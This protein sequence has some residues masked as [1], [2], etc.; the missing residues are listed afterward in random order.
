MPR[1]PISTSARMMACPA[2]VQYVEVSTVARPVTVTA[3]VDWKM[4]AW[5]AGRAFS[6]ASEREEQEPACRRTSGRGRRAAA[7]APGAGSPSAWS[8]GAPP[9]RT[10]A[11]RLRRS[12][13]ACQ[14]QDD[15]GELHVRSRQRPQA[16][17]TPAVR[18]LRRSSASSSPAPNRLWV[19]GSGIGLG[20]GALPLFLL[21]RDRLGDSTRLVWLAR[22]AAE[23]EEA[24]A[25]GFDAD[26]QGRA[27]RLLDHAAG[28]RHR[29][30][31]RVRRR[32]PLRRPRRLR[33]AALARP[34][35]QAPAPRLA[36]DVLGVVPARPRRRTP[37]AR[38]RLPPRRPRAVAVPGGVGAGPAEHRQRVRR[39]SGE[40][41]RHRRP[42]RRRAARRQRVDPPRTRPGRVLDEAVPDLPPSAR[43]V[44]FAPTW[45]DGG[46]DPTVPTA[47]E[48]DAIVAWLE[49]H[50][51]VLLVRTH[52]L[53]R[54][55]LRRRPGPVGA[56]PAA[57]AGPA[58]RRQPGP[59]GGRRRGHRLLLDRLRL[60]AG[61]TPGGVL[62]A[63][64]RRLRLDARLLPAVRGVHRR[65][66]RHHLGRCA[67]PARRGARRGSGRTGPPPRAAPA[68]G[69]LRRPR[70]PRRPIGCS[71]RSWPAPDCPVVSAR[72]DAGVGRPT[73]TGALVRPGH[74]HAHDRRTRGRGGAGRPPGPRRGGRRV[75][76][77][78]RLA[79]GLRPAGPAERHL[80]ARARRRLVAG[81]RRRRAAGDPPR[82][83]PRDRARA[84]RRTRRRG[85]TASRGRRA[86]RRGAEVARDGVPTLPARR[87]RTPSSW[88]A[89]ADARRPATRAASAVPWPGCGRRLV[90][91]GA[92]STGRCRF[93]TGRFG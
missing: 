60:R 13:V 77:P 3:D 61:R 90:G 67:R 35:V 38:D 14:N 9:D 42:T 10:A 85:R 36:V 63:R 26:P 50:D 27:P 57:R 41:R 29:R 72:H 80:P 24:R 37:D 15:H 19:F 88:R 55:S 12:S 16:P 74:R 91:T 31:P 53:G 40:R 32:E 47:A 5:Q 51:A 93:P 20:E 49:R 56:H 43:I 92:S 62:R 58:A 45:R 54:G 11:R 76:R 59:V 28:P 68:R 23:L 82:A 64:P 89:S 33:R 39:R 52:P 1:P 22:S 84:R 4:A 6:R 18:V 83:V 65:P 48:W 2:G 46:A 69:V 17:R 66:G 21:A 7:A 44:L 78:A 86:R 81:R 8:V 73:V 75:V 79:L 71:T 70:R 25:L 87:S 34:A 30:D